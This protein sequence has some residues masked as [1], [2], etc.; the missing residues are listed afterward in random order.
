MTDNLQL[1]PELKEIAGSI[2]INVSGQL[3]GILGF[4]NLERV[5]R[6][7]DLYNGPNLQSLAGFGNL[8]SIGEHSGLPIL[9]FRIFRACIHFPILAGYKF[10]QEPTALPPQF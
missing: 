6:G 2:K 7:I 9:A 1:F 8:D 4:E 3:T 5:G 10:K